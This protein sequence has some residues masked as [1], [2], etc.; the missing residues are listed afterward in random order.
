MAA[1]GW[2]RK[3][4]VT[5]C[6]ILAI[7]PLRAAMI[8]VRELTAAAQAAVTGCGWHSC[9]PRRAARMASV[10]PAMPRRRARLSAAAICA[11]VSLA[12]RVGGPSEQVQRIRRIQLLEGLQRGGEVLTQL[13]PQPLHLPG[14]LPD[15]RLVSAGGHLDGLGPGAVTGYRP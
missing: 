8:T 7:S 13:V 10:L 1:S 14:P 4:A 12:G 6:S 5:C 9:S 2:P 3:H 15:Q 11:R